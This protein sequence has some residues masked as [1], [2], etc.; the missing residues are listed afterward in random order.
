M[1]PSVKRRM[2]KSTTLR[3]KMF[4]AEGG[5]YVRGIQSFALEIRDQSVGS[6]RGLGAKSCVRAVVR[7]SRP[8]YAFQPSGK[9][10]STMAQ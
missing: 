8:P 6:R 3:G 4:R 7:S 9:C 10:D 5:P 2:A 1:I